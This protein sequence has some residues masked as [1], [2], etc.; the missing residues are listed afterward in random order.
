[1]AMNDRINLSEI[2]QK[3]NIAIEAINENYS[4]KEINRMLDEILRDVK[5]LTQ[6]FEEEIQIHFYEKPYINR[7]RPATRKTFK[8]NLKK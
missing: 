1:M 5:K 8:V 7:P 6:Y 4:E 2:M 3:V